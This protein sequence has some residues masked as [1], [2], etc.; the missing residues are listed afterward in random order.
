MPK[1]V[2]NPTLGKLAEVEGEERLIKE[3]RAF[4][5]LNRNVQNQSL[6]HFLSP[7]EGILKN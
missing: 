4:L 7:S 3:A 6:M 1:Q 5:F 2:L